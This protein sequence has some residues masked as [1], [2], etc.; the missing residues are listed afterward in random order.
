MQLS[1]NR[2]SVGNDR[3]AEAPHFGDLAMFCMKC[4]GPGEGKNAHED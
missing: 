1:V 4:L 2:Y 3:V